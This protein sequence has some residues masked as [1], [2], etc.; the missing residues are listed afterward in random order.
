M[1]NITNHPGCP[2]R[3]ENGNCLRVGGFCSSVPVIECD[4]VLSGD[5]VNRQGVINIVAQYFEKAGNG[6][7]DCS[8]ADKRKL[9]AAIWSMPSERRTGQWEPILNSKG[10]IVAH[11]CSHCRNI[12]HYRHK[13][14]FCQSC[15]A[16]MRKG[17][18]TIE[19]EG[20]KYENL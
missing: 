17:A 15:G 2:F 12:S 19:H 8:G 6:S 4:T 16:D 11:R 10:D 7:N 20:V 9:F 1:G 14:D 5:T 18:R 3:H 13:S